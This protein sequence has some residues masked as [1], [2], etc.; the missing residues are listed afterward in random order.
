MLRPFKKLY[1]LL[2]CVV[3]VFF[4][5]N[6]AMLD[7]AQ[8]YYVAPD[9]NDANS[10]SR[11]APFASLARARDAVRTWRTSNA[12][13][14][15]VK[16][17]G[18][19][20][21]LRNTLRFDLRDSCPST[22]TTTFRAATGQR[23]VVSAAWPITGW[24]KMT[25]RPEGCTEDVWVADLPEGIDWIT[26]L[27]DAEGL[28]LRAREP[29][30]FPVSG[31]GT[32]FSTTYKTGDVA[33]DLDVGNAE[34]NIVPD[35]PW[36]QSILTIT[37][38]DAQRRILKTAV[39]ATYVMN[40][41]GFGKFPGGSAFIENTMAGM[42]RPGNWCVNRRTRKVYLIPRSG[43]PGDDI[44]APA[45]TELISIKGKIN[46]EG[47]SDEP[48]RGIVFEGLTF[49]HGDR[50][51]WQKTKQG[52]GLQHEPCEKGWPAAARRVRRSD[53]QDR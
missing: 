52:W 41:P 47:P 51:A 14:V 49:M 40:P 13:D 19:V 3:S 53:S 50:W 30:F 7:A 11:T 20:Y 35:R 23:P 45:L 17:S 18:G 39:P 2:C 37:E 28:L 10:G 32:L 44:V 24:T 9:G 5:S 12:G 33:A 31:K 29:G 1:P 25:A 15:V 36:S 26:T 21:R 4:C 27:Y 22:T 38:H 43:R 8:T 34:L 16:V 48:I 46:Y 6:A 42:Q